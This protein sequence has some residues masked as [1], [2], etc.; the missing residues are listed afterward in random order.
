MKILIISPQPFFRVRGTCIAIRQLAISL[1]QL[2]HD[3]KIISFPFG[4]ESGVEGLRH[5]RC[6]G[7]P[8]IKDVPIGPS[9]EK[10]VLDLFLLVKVL[11]EAMISKYDVIH[12]VEE[13]GFFIPFLKSLTKAVFVFDMDSI[14]SEQ[15]IYSGFLKDGVI[16]KLIRFWEKTCIK[17]ADF[18]LSVSPDITEYA[19]RYKTSDRV[20]QVED[21]PTTSPRAE[22]ADEELAELKKR[23]NLSDEKVILYTGNLER[24]QGMEL[25]LESLTHLL[26]KFS[27]VKLLIV[28]VDHVVFCGFQDP[29]KIPHFYK[30]S[31]VLVS[32]RNKGKNIPL[33]IY[34][35]LYSRVPVVATDLP[36][37]SKILDESI[38]VLA[39]PE[40]EAFSEG[41]LK[42]LRN[43]DFAGEIAKNAFDFIEKNYSITE[44]NK[45]VEKCY[46]KV[47]EFHEMKGSSKKEAWHLKL[48]SKSIK[49]LQKFKT[50]S[51]ILPD[52]NGKSCIEI[53]A[54]KGAVTYFLRE[55]KGGRWF[56][57]ILDHKF[58]PIAKELLKDDVIPIDPENLNFQDSSFDL[59]LA[60][61]P[62]HVERDDVFFKEIHR[63][64][65]DDGQ[66]WVISPH[67]GKG[68][69]L[70]TIKN[71]VGLTMEQYG[72]FRE[73]YSM[74]ELEEK[75]SKSG[76]KTFTAGSYSKLF[77]ESIEL[78]LNAFYT[79]TKKRK[80]KSSSYRPTTGE[81]F[82]ESGMMFRIYNIVFPLL[83]AIAAF[84]ILLPCMRGYVLYIGA[85]KG[86]TDVAR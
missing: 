39:E 48:A 22:T 74:K 59:V 42:I 70:N 45:K 34:D 76:F 3:V 68:M 28:G 71:K 23:L 4:G 49:K 38:A 62:E 77:G 61:R 47:R 5:E 31:H 82:K 1:L 6:I 26:K 64:L 53:G 63:I 20:F 46:I 78:L 18:I 51:S 54:E 7:L 72:H 57:G 37:H 69:F 67:T 13:A 83:R 12:P 86:G 56:A 58:V 27:N 52:C 35:Y 79:F 19:L 24:Y 8:F 21:F 60:S 84:D 17:K 32:P 16:V 36:M 40:P 50:V 85:E 41:I 29:A 14:L 73:G 33:K 75:L 30:I 66:L 65:K 2:G 80:D 11:K 25:L 10:L 9:K 43:P 15:L 44:F 81:E 55:N